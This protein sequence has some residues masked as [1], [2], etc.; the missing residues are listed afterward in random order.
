[1]LGVS[2]RVRYEMPSSHI[3][4]SQV[5][6][7]PLSRAKKQP[8]WPAPENVKVLDDLTEFNYGK[9]EGLTTDEIRR[10]LQGGQFGL[11]RALMERR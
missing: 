6:V 8:N 2:R 7:S 10:K 11:I 4:F 9:Y 1:M 3:D 5:L